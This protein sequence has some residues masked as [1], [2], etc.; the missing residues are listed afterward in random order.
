[1]AFTAGAENAATLPPNGLSGPP[2]PKLEPF[3]PNTTPDAQ[4]GPA[5]HAPIY[6][7][8][9]RSQWDGEIEWD[10]DIVDGDMLSSNL[11]STIGGV[12]SG[13]DVL[14]PQL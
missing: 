14:L 7:D 6:W 12:A 5:R 4:P 10:S 13:R 3:I 2:S 1:M 8:E 11:V 9:D